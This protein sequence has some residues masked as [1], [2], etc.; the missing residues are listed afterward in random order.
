MILPKLKPILWLLACLLLISAFVLILQ[1]TSGTLKL[2][3]E[4]QANELRLDESEWVS[5][6]E[7]LKA[8]SGQNSELLFRSLKKEQSA[9]LAGDTGPILMVREPEIV[10]GEMV[11][12]VPA[13]L[14]IE[15]QENG[16]ALNLESLAVIIKKGWLLSL[17][18]TDKIKPYL[19]GNELKVSGLKIPSGEY[20]VQFSISDVRGNATEGIFALSIL[21]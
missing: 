15:F 17:D 11:L 4:D 7:R 16:E 20:E 2:F 14:H 6:R 12:Q 8:S 13:S 3:S 10:D 19:S 1:A 18:V 9:N 5:L 21:D